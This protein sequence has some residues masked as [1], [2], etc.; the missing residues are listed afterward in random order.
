MLSQLEDI[1]RPNT[2]PFLYQKYF[3][4]CHFKFCHNRRNHFISTQ[5]YIAHQEFVF[6]SHFF[7]PFIRSYLADI[8]KT[9]HL[10]FFEPL[11]IILGTKENV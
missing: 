6:S 3:P 1:K 8:K 7:L 2:L 4:F 10:P 9:Y 11:F 5:S